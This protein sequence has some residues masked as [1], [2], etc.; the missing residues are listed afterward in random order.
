MEVGRPFAGV[1]K[2]GELSQT[3]HDQL[4]GISPALTVDILTVQQLMHEQRT[5]GST[6]RYSELS[7]SLRP[8]WSLP[9]TGYL[10]L[11]GPWGPGRFAFRLDQ[12]PCQS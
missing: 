9:F 6:A 5:D 8:S 11:L 4:P 1:L 2:A 12:V 3:L 7:P 10:D